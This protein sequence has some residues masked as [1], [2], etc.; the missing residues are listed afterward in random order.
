MAETEDVSLETSMVPTAGALGV[1]GL[2]A[3]EER[4]RRGRVA[5]GVKRRVRAGLD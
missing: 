2:G 5:V 3:E 4:K 1:C